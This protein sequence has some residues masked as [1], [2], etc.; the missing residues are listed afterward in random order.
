MAPSI[1][2][3]GISL[4]VLAVRPAAAV[5]QDPGPRPAFSLSP[6][7]AKPSYFTT[8]WQ[9]DEATRGRL[10][11]ITSHRSNYALVF[12]YN[13]WPNEAP[14]QQVDPAMTLLKPEFKFQLSFKIK[15][16]EDLFGGPV[17]LW[18]GYTQRSF[19]QFYALSN[20]SPFR[21]T[22]YEPE[23]LFNVR[24]R[25]SVFGLKA[26]F[27]QLGL[28]H[29][30]NGRTRPLSRTWDRIVVNVGLERGALSLLLKGWYHI[31]HSFEETKNPRIDD[32]MGFGE[33]WGFYVLKKH[34]L[35]VMLRNN[36]DLRENYGAVKLEWSFPLFG[37]IAG[38][39]Q[40]F[41]GYGESLID[42]DHLVSRLGIGFI[43]SDWR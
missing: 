40:W 7:E 9:L 38:D 17:D 24:T 36:L 3:L 20:S 30:S 27:I 26:R 12:S 4:F 5:P 39:V 25:F 22:N 42:H 28:N 34:R 11:S 18:F 29:Q 13:V 41:Y 2:L 33:A 16:W 8:L 10:S 1:A 31:P 37:R 21:E 15:V 32:Y 35:A 14:L 19:W 43:L 23:V 6:S